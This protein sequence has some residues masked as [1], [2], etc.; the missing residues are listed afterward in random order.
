MFW[1]R[2]LWKKEDFIR[3]YKYKVGFPID[4]YAKK[5]SEEILN[6]ENKKR[7]SINPRMNLNKFL[8]YC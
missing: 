1:K 7:N 6:N 3:K 4:Y 5:E 2:R 8:E